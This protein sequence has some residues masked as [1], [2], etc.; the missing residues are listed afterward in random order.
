LFQGSQF[1]NLC[2]GWRKEYAQTLPDLKD[3]DIGGSGFAVTSYTV[4]KA[5]GGEA[6][7]ARLRDR[8]K[9]RGFRLMLDF[10]P[11]HMGVG[12]VWTKDHADYFVQGT[13]DDLKR[14]ADAFVA[15][16]GGKS[17]LAHGKV[18]S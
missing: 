12:H 9:K 7:L 16:N 5:L 10:V 8:L 18:S 13:Q 1:A 14:D 15:V 2:A 3:E 17:V 11:N 4:N 6:A